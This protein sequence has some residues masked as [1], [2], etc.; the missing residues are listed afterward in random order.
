MR[1]VCTTCGPS[2]VLAETIDVMCNARSSRTSFRRRWRSIDWLACADGRLRQCGGRHGTLHGGGWAIGDVHG[3][4]A[5]LDAADTMPT[6][7]AMHSAGDAVPVLAGRGAVACPKGAAEYVRATEADAGSDAIDGGLVAGESHTRLFQ[8]QVF[9]E[10]FGVGAEGVR[11]YAPEM[12]GT[13]TRSR[14]RP[15]GRPGRRAGRL[16]CHERTRI[17]QGDGQALIPAAKGKGWARPLLCR[18]ET[19]PAALLGVIS[20]DDPI[21]KLVGTAEPTSAA[22]SRLTRRW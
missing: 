2:Y 16:P 3:C 13:R 4:I 18:P 8:P 7:S 5:K 12:T 21:A 11:E 19:L 6:I 9:Q 15:H 14:V 20:A 17:D 10:S 22:S 1:F